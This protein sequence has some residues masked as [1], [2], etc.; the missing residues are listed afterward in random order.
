MTTTAFIGT[1]LTLVCILFFFMK[2]GQPAKEIA[3]S[4]FFFGVFLGLFGAS[5]AATVCLNLMVNVILIVGL[6]NLIEWLAIVG[7]TRV[8]EFR[9]RFAESRVTH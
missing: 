7:T 2:A 5:S 3:G 6:I 4:L 8:R 9:L 1:A